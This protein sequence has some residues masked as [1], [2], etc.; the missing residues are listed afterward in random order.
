VGPIECQ[1][2][3]YVLIPTVQVRENRR[4][5]ESF[6]PISVL[7][8][9]LHSLEVPSVPESSL[10]V[11]PRLFESVNVLAPYC[12]NLTEALLHSRYEDKPVAGSLPE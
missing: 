7:F 4:E 6:R 11:V 5:V 1:D 3:T 9:H 8:D 2:F 10:I 12:D